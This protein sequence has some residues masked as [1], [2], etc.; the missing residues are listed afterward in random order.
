MFKKV[1]LLLLMV[2]YT[3][4]AMA[5]EEAKDNSWCA[6]KSNTV[7]VRTGPGKRYPI[8]WVYK[9][10]NLPMK[11]LAE[12]DNWIKVEDYQGVTGWVHPSMISNKSTFIVT[13]DLVVLNKDS[14]HENRHIAKLEKGVIGDIIECEDKLCKVKTDNW[15]GYVSNESIWGLKEYDAE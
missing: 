1:L 11:R 3:S 7:N 10:K 13:D 8:K 15:E 2:L 9:R 4:S 5:E 12:Y 14:K 6:L